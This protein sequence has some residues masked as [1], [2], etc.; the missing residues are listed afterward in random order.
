[1][2]P[3][4]FLE[5][6]EFQSLVASVLPFT[7]GLLYVWYN[8]HA[9]N[10]LH[11]VLFFIVIEL[12]HMAVNANDNTQDFVHAKDE[13]TFKQLTNVVGHYH[14]SL[15]LAITVIVSLS[16]GAAIIG[17]GLLK[18]TWGSS[19]WI[20]LGMGI[21]GFLV[22]YFY[23][24]GPLPI[25]NTPFGEL[26][27]GI[28]M[29]YVIMLAAVYVNLAPARQL[30]WSLAGNVLLASGL[31]VFAIGNLMLANNLC[32]YEEDKLNERRTIVVLLGQRVMLWAWNIGYALGYVCMVAAV[33]VGTL[34]KLTLLALLI[35]PV[36]IKNNRQFGAVMV[37]SKSFVLAVKNCI[38]ITIS[39]ALAMGI[40]IIFHL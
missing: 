25:S 28:T 27:S 24:G 1:M 39:F 21:I 5:F 38:L 13:K 8:Y 12:M 22:G 31:A 30:S 11:S 34:P 14:I 35:V 16:A 23:A 32:D 40:G 15:R 3:K 7:L 29:G 17:L 19:S 26:F 10:L 33:L 20:F 2:K 37:K 4:V 9:F 36:V 18:L 6:V